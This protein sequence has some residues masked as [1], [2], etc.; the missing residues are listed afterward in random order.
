MKIFIFLFYPIAKPL[1][2]I[3]DCILGEEV[4]NSQFDDAARIIVGVYIYHLTIF[5]YLI[6]GRNHT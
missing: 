3:L 4:Y 1:A 5:L 2:A 6:L